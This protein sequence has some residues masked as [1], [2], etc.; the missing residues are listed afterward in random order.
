MGKMEDEGYLL[1]GLDVVITEEINNELI[2]TDMEVYCKVFII[3][4]IPITGYFVVPIGETLLDVEPIEVDMINNFIWTYKIDKLYVRDNGLFVQKFK[5]TIYRN[6]KEFCSATYGDI[7][8]TEKNLHSVLERLH[9]KRSKV[10]FRMKDFKERLVGNTFMVSNLTF[11][12]IDYIDGENKIK[13]RSVKDN[14]ETILDAF[15]VNE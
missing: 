11:E 5:Y 14:S 8:T 15:I 4:G 1:T 12:V 13:V 6:N 3:D 2:S 10:D 9:T 7:T